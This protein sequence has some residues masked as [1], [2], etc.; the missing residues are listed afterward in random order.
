MNVVNNKKKVKIPKKKNQRKKKNNWPNQ[1]ETNSR[2]KKIKRNQEIDYSKK[3]VRKE[4][5]D[6][7]RYNYLKSVRKY[8][9]KNNWFKLI[10]LKLYQLYHRVYRY[11]F[12]CRSRMFYQYTIYILLYYHLFFDD[13]Y[14]CRIHFSIL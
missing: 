5:L 7:L 6:N 10:T 9:E 8:M 12:F 11:H 1:K 3:K 14:F 13:Y 2:P 4:V